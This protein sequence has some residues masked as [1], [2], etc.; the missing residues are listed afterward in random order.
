VSFVWNIRG[1]SVVPVGVLPDGGPEMGRTMSQANDMAV[2]F[3]ARDVHTA[4]RYQHNHMR[5]DLMYAPIGFALHQ[6]QKS[7]EE[8]WERWNQ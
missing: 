5:C 2:S 4:D 1:Q 8:S 7:T 6:Q 3:C